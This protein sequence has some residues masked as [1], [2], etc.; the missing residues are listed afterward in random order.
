MIILFYLIF[1]ILG[2]QETEYFIRAFCEMCELSCIYLNIPSSNNYLTSN[3]L[4]WAHSHRYTL[5]YAHSHS[6]CNKLRMVG[7]S[8]RPFFSECVRLRLLK[9]LQ[10]IIMSFREIP[11][12]FVCL[13]SPIKHICIATS[14]FWNIDNKFPKKETIKQPKINVMK[15]I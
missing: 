3:S 2:G 5:T 9:E 8:S 7:N 15:T 6:T 11:G 14:L 1:L 13:F 12:L 4:Y 10:K